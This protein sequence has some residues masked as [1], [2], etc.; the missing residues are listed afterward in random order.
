MPSE[1]GGLLTS[2][3]SDYSE[4]SEFGQS[5]MTNSAI[6][7]ESNNM[8]MHGGDAFQ[9]LRATTRGTN[10][11]SIVH[12]LHHSTSLICSTESAEAMK[13]LRW[14]LIFNLV[15]IALF[16]IAISTI[17]MTQ[18]QAWHNQVTLVKM[19]VLVPFIVVG[20]GGF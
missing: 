9:R 12:I 7:I 18:V 11:T 20:G 14:L 8:S 13:P 10:G 15:I 4:G 17:S 5:N 6:T 19:V 1:P 3:H 16:V 2:R